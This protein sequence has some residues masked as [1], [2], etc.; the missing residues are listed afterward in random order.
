[1]N[2]KITVVSYNILARLL[3]TEK[4]FLPE[5]YDPSFILYENRYTRLWDNLEKYVADRSIIC[6]QDNPGSDSVPLVV[7]VTVS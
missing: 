2:K 1:M 5:N 6:L 3:C 4:N 7:G